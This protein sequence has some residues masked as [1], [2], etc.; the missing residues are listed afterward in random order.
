MI[1]GT[2]LVDESAGGVDCFVTKTQM[3]RTWYGKLTAS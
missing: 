3:V 1:S 2:E